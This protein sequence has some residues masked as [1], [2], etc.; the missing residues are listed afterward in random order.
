MVDFVNVPQKRR[1]KGKK[2]RVFLVFGKMNKR[3]TE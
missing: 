2:D 1:K 3:K